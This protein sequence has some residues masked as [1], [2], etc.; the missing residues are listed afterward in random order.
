ME[1]CKVSKIQEVKKQSPDHDPVLF[2]H[3]SICAGLQSHEETMADWG[4]RGDFT[5]TLLCIASCVLL[6][7]CNMYTAGY[8]HGR[9]ETS[10]PQGCTIHCTVNQRK[11]P[12]LPQMPMP[13]SNCDFPPS[14]SLPIS[15]PEPLGTTWP[16]SAYGLAYFGHF[17]EMKA[18]IMWSSVS[19]HLTHYSNFCIC[20][21]I[22]ELHKRKTN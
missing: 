13:S 11:W 5:D 18:P 8:S 14:P 9:C 16:L 7:K 1:Q 17:N 15:F 2:R 6:L 12:T 19:F 3:G 22:S 4:G 10:C 20:T 21:L